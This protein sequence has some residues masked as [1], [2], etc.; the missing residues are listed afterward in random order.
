MGLNVCSKTAFINFLY[1]LFICTNFEAVHFFYSWVTILISITLVSFI[2]W[3][4]SHLL[5][6]GGSHGS[7]RIIC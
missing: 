7:V 4:L 6:S 2:H 5:L 1:L 3:L